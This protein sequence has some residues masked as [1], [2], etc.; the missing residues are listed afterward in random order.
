MT[1]TMLSSVAARILVGSRHAFASSGD[2]ALTTVVA[3]AVGAASTVSGVVTPRPSRAPQI[4]SP[5]LQQQEVA[6][7]TH[8]RH[9]GTSSRNGG[10]DE[11]DAGRASSSTSDLGPILRAMPRA[12]L[13]YARLMRLDKPIGSWLLLWPCF[14]S[15][16]LAA[17]P[18]HLPDLNTL[19][20]FGCGA[21][22]LR[23]AG[24]T[25]NDLW[26]RDIDA[27]VQRT[28]S[29]PLASKEISPT[30]ALAFL[31]AQLSLGL[32]VLVQLNPFSQ[33]LG[34]ASMPLVVA[35]PL[36]KRITG[37][38][39]AFL[40]LTINWGALLGWAAVKGNL[41]LAVAL[42]LYAS[43]VAWT[44]VYD[45][46]Y[47]HQDKADDVKIG[48]RSTALTFGARNR[49]VLTAFALAHGA[50][51][52]AAGHFAGCDAAFHAAAAVGAAGWLRRIWTIDLDSPAECSATFN[53]NKAYGAFVFA[54]IV[55]DRAL[56]IS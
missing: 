1:T 56:L 12:A 6:A 7:L 26:D 8:A 33:V 10:G 17:D 27:K 46:I 32:G 36:M 34:L 50:G 48:V 18:G 54:A 22:L 24:C 28:K 52:L 40:G 42:P 9:L 13:P 20:L 25:I 21:V 35:Y 29:R 11:N 53:D 43:C 4:G 14:W 16:G 45:T 37:W 49:E 51:L 38:P 5:F 19:A 30:G 2:R 23:G 39:Q 55:A 44:I 47:A 3:S 41:D 31:G 15:I